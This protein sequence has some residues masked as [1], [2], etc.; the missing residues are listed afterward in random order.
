MDEHTQDT[1]PHE[2]LDEKQ[3]EAIVTGESPAE[4]PV[5]EPEQPRF[6]SLRWRLLLPIFIV[7]LIGAMVAAYAIIGNL[8]GGV[9]VS[10]SNILLRNSRAVAERAA[11]FY[12]R[13]R[14]EAQRIAFTVGVPEAIRTGQTESLH[15]MLEGLAAAGGLDSVIVTDPAGEEVLGLQRVETNEFTDFAISSSTDLGEQP[16]IRDVLDEGLN[17]TTGFMRTPE[18]LVLYTAVPIRYENERAGIALAGHRLPA[19]LEALEGSS[20]ADVTLYGEDGTLLET[21]FTLN[22]ES[23]ALLSLDSAIVNQTLASTEAVTTRSGVQVGETRY[24]AV[25]FPF[26]YGPNILGVVSTFMPDTVPFATE[27]PRQVT[28][29][30]VAALAGAVVIVAFVGVSR[31]AG[32]AEQ[33]TAVARALA[34]GEQARTGMQPG[35]EIRAIGHALDQYADS[36]QERDDQLRAMLRKNRRQR[37]YLHMVLQAMPHG[38]IVQAPDGRVLVI[39][40]SARD[41]L[42]SQRVFR[43][44]GLHE[45]SQVVSETLGPALAPGIYALGDP[46]RLDLDGRM[47]QAQ[48]AAILSMSGRVGT[49]ILL[50]D[51]TDEVR[52][53]QAREELLDRLAQDIHQPLSG[54]AQTGGHSPNELVH[55]FAREISRHAAA[56]QKMIVDMREITTIDSEHLKRGQRP[57]ALE[58]LVWAVVNDWR[59]IAGAAGL[60]LHVIIEHKGLFVLGDERRLRWAIGNIIDNAIKYTPADGALTVEIKDV[61]DGMV[62][63]RVRDNGVGI[64]HD[65]LPHLFTPFYRG[66]PVTEDGDV[67]RVPGMG[68]GLNVAQQIIEAHGGSIRVKSR[69]HVGSAVYFSL[70]LTASEGLSLP[71][72]DDADMEGETVRLSGDVDIADM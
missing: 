68:Q 63:L 3:V 18:G 23:S 59:Q 47:V 12:D 60:T 54:L 6:I 32:R 43:S 11:D 4:Q 1:A 55:A 27:L 21:T 48:A 25:Y 16:L 41:L 7:I 19:V 14:T 30:A 13:Q 62:H 66:T 9:A 5:G 42:G 34:R 10:Q 44:S 15:A 22:D 33:V 57:L 69:Q 67:I 52:R 2:V 64:A 31:L 46:Y 53:E 51:I 20:V 28:A 36:V 29:L 37:A 70:P 56:L 24:E 71:R 8:S 49:V 35:G 61:V 65:D 40:D 38:V 39:N 58:T 17:G 72:F 45:I 50:R 26:V